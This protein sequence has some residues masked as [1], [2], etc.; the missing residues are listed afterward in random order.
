MSTEHIASTTPGRLPT[1]YIPHGGGPC[2]FMDWNPPHAWDK[3]AAYLR[4]IVESLPQRPRAIVMVSAHWL[5]GDF[6]VTGARSP[7]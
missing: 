6:A 4:G 5:E 7:S 1:V 3:T 2:F